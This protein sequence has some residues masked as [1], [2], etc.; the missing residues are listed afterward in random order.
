MGAKMKKIILILS[1]ITLVFGFSACQ[2]K[3]FS[4]IDNQPP[5]PPTGL[6]VLNG[7][8]VVDISWNYNHESDV[9]GYNVYYAYSYDG[10]Y[11]LIGSTENNYFT[12]YE[13]H[14]GTTYYYAVT[15]YDYNGNESD[16]SYNDVNA[17]PRPE[18]FNET[19]FDYINFPDMGGFSFTTYSDVPYDDNS[20][21]F[22]FENYNGTYYID[23]WQDSDIQ[24]MGQTQ[25]IYNIPYAP[26]GGWS[27]TKDAIAIPGH[28]YVIWTWDNH[29]AKIRV[30][31]ISSERLVFDWAFQTVKGNA[32]L[33]TKNV[34]L[35]RG[36]LTKN[37]LKRR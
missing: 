34:P 33:K 26:A 35:Q 11:S 30:K 16:L 23:V 9:A 37:T 28:T 15:A 3:D 27:S 2:F 22:Y 8:N 7:D 19:V 24:D 4:H 1:I 20:A 25:D 12:D 32:M 21:D 13:A 29:Y 36:P 31:S 6:K 17:T 10:K 18:G 5:S 14:N